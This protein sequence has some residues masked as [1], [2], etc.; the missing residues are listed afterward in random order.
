MIYTGNF[1]KM[2]FIEKVGLTPV[3]IARQPPLWYKGLEYKALAPRA[4]LLQ[5]Y[6]FIGDKQFYIKQFNQM[7]DQLNPRLVYQDL[8]SMVDGIDVVLL[9]Y[10]KPT[11]FCHRHLVADWFNANGIPCQEIQ[12]GA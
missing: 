6:R 9:C 3:S 10:E 12:N 1:A 4:E 7:L 11:D 8:L 2:K 5:A